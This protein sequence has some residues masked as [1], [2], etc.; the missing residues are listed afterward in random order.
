MRHYNFVITCH[1][2]PEQYDVYEGDKKVAYVRYRWGYCT[3][4]PYRPDLIERTNF[5]T[6][7][8]EVDQD[9]DFDT[10]IFARAYGD[11]LDGMFR[12]YEREQIL[13]DIDE[14]IYNWWQNFTY[15]DNDLIINYK[16]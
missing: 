11:G 4:N 6:G 5:W 3:V 13:D 1:G 16:V 14:A 7:K 15:N 9:I 8:V 12:E 2:C 10:E